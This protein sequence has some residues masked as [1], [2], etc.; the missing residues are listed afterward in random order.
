[1]VVTSSITRKQLLRVL[2]ALL[3]RACVAVDAVAYRPSI[4]KLGMPLPRWWNCEL[5]R[6]SIRLDDRW[7]TRFWDDYWED[8]RPG[9]VCDICGRRA[10]WLTYRD[11]DP[12]EEEVSS[13]DRRP[14]EVDIDICYWCRLEMPITSESELEAAIAEARR[15]SVSWRWRRPP[16]MSLTPTA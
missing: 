10:S 5:A 3:N 14:V 2:V 13:E 8:W 9:G 15:R 7:E 1:M 6:L 16:T 4:V 11:D 12:D